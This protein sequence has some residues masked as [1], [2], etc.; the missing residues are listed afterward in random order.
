MACGQVCNGIDLWDLN[1]LQIKRK[2]VQCLKLTKDAVMLTLQASCSTHNVM[3]HLLG[4][5]TVQ[6]RYSNVIRLHLVTPEGIWP[7]NLVNGRLVQL[8]FGGCVTGGQKCLELTSSQKAH[9]DS[10]E[11]AVPITCHQNLPDRS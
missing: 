7:L 4:P 2:Q 6:Q 1:Y 11:P 10:Y 5:A 8:N 9:T 3:H